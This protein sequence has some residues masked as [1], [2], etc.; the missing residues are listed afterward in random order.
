MEQNG[1]A[2]AGLRRGLGLFDATMLV[3]G[4]IIG[5]G[6][7]LV[8]SDIARQ[9]G[10]PGW[11]LIV[12]V[13]GA[14]LTMSAA[15][16]Y[17]ELAAMMPRAGG[18]YV[19]LREA[20]GPVTGFLY[21]WTPFL[22]IQTGSIAAVAVAFARYLGVL[23]PWVSSRPLLGPISAQHLVALALIG[24]LTAVNLRGIRA[25]KRVQNLFTL[26]KLAALAFLIVLGILYGS[27]EPVAG[28]GDF[29][30]TPVGWPAFL[31]LLA[32]AMVGALFA[33]DAWNN[34]TFT[35]GEVVNPRRNL[36]A[37]LL[38]GTGL[39][40]AVYI[41][42]N[43]A[44]VLNLPISA[45]QHAPGDRIATAVAHRILGEPAEAFMAIAILIATVG[46]DNGMILAGS[47]VY[48]AMARDGVFFE[49]TGRLNRHSVPGYSLALQACWAGLLTLSGTYSDL[50]DYVIFA[51]LLFY[52]MTV[53]AVFRLRRIR[54]DEPRPYRALGYP[55]LPAVY[56]GAACLILVSLLFQKPQYTVRGLAI[57]LA[58]LPAYAMWTR[59]KVGR[60]PNSR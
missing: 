34:I 55:V 4:T 28:S 17:G 9:V 33:Y 53:A 10:S 48:Y 40:A 16:S 20:W 43:V 59:A 23:V 56:I 51:A 36:P 47:R 8:S 54:P 60:R 25:G 13:I 2:E 11:L 57:V 50:V 58:G 26:A 21:G 30:A 1:N 5:S 44:Y 52:L 22:V 14:V 37:S 49:R 41:L 38:L 29:W 3:A 6:I 7:F 24:T 42:I 31:P 12:W 46:S 39:V 32:V 15:L 45:I 18:Q 19:Y 27:R 35:A